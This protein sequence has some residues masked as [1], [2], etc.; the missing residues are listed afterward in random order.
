MIQILNGSSGS[1][2]KVGP[3]AITRPQHA[4]ESISALAELGVRRL[5][6]QPMDARLE[7]VRDLRVWLRENGWRISQVRP[8]HTATA[9][10]SKNIP[11]SFVSPS[12]HFYGANEHATLTKGFVTTKDELST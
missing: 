12:S 5:V 9:T 3:N 11:H 4:H 7:Y 2:K 6:L 1:H 10:R 8:S